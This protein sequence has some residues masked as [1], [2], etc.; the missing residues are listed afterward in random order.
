[1]ASWTCRCEEGRRMTNAL[2]FLALLIVLIAVIK[3][4]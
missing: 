4:K 3:T 1:M 2:E